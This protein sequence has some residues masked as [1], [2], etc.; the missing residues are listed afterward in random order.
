MPYLEKTLRRQL[1]TTIDKAR[2]V[3]EEGAADAIRRLAVAEAEAP[4]WLSEPDRMLRRTL[5]AHGRSLGDTLDGAP[6]CTWHLI[7]TAAF[8]HWHR[9]LFGRFLVERG[10]L[11]H[12]TLGAAIVRDELAELAA[13]EGLPDAWRDTGSSLK[14]GMVLSRVLQAVPHRPAVIFRALLRVFIRRRG[15]G[16]VRPTRSTRDT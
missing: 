14:T 6:G 3:A 10:L 7:E 9:M 15:L 1:A 16:G 2:L 5:R 11:I 4:A 12:P 8:E 13:E